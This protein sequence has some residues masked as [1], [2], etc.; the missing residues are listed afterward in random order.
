[1]RRVRS[2]G[3]KTTEI[4]FVTILRQARI[5]GWRRHYKIEGKPD[6]AFPV[7]R[8][9]VFVD[10]CFWHGC[11]RC[12]TTPRTNRRFWRRKLRRNKARDRLVTKA[13][14]G[15]GWRV[16]R[17]WECTLRSHITVL[18]RLRAALGRA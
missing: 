18:R 4:K 14:A 6:F 5:T 3:N 9:A 16:L 7:S 12:Y 8:T 2:R 17:F 11:P 10:G 15:Q 1:M 13:L